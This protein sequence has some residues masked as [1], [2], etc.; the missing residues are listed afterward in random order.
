MH[1]NAPMSASPAPLQPV[2]TALRLFILASW[3]LGPLLVADGLY[4]RIAGAYVSVGVLAGWVPAAQ[5][6]GAGPLDSGWWF[7]VTGLGLI[8]ASFGVYAGHSWGYRIGL[9]ASI[10]ALGY[11]YLG[12]P[13][14]LLCLAGLLWPS[15]RARFSTG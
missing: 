8:S 5:A 2:P 15:T 13:L 9:A 14:A 7:I 4:Q 11:L 10:L 12:T 3:L 6:L 1:A